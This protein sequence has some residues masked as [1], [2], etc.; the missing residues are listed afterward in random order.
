MLLRRSRKKK[1]KKALEAQQAAMAAMQGIPTY[2]YPRPPSAM[3]VPAM[4][5]DQNEEGEPLDQSGSDDM[6]MM[7]SLSLTGEVGYTQQKTLD[8]VSPQII[9]HQSLPL[10]HQSTA[11]PLVP[12]SSQPVPILATTSSGYK[13]PSSDHIL[14][15]N[16][17]QP[18]Q[19][20][21]LLTYPQ[22][23]PMANTTTIQEYTVTQPSIKDTVPVTTYNSLPRGLKSNNVSGSKKSYHSQPKIDPAKAELIK[24]AVYLGLGRGIDAT[25]K[26]PWTNKTSFQV[27]RVHNSVVE[28]N[29]GGTLASY[30]HEILSIASLDEQFQASLNPPECPINIHVEADINRCVNASR[31]VIG[32]RVFTRTIGFQ[33]DIEEKYTDGE[34]QRNGKETHLVPRDPTEIVYNSQNSALTF[35]ER[36]YHWL[37]QKIAHKCAMIGQRIDIRS[38]ENYADQLTKLMHSNKTLTRVDEEIKAGCR[39]IIQSLRITHYVTSIR[40]GAAEYRVMSEGEYHKQLALGGAFG[41]DSLAVEATT[42][43]TKQTKKEAFRCS[44]LR[45]IGCIDENDKVEKGSEG[46][47]VLTLQVQPITRLIRVPAVKA[48][49]IGAVENYMERTSAAEGTRSQK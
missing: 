41:L 23:I 5:H 40:L 21:H 15:R 42:G 4:L 18:A 37:L 45:K 19:L 30:D 13:P 31:Y 22:P 48:A 16:Q 32:K 14:K 34:S 8:I 44:Q 2:P 20:A 10:S 3:S 1:Q 12:V 27:R 7:E 9:P 33:T 36:L 25:K 47:T 46:E 35:E 43:F 24:T 39:E 29:E 49:L 28:T 17:S 38:D 6:E 26:N 11:P